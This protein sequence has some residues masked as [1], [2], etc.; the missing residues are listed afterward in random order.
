MRQSLLKF[1][2]RLA[3][4]RFNGLD[5]GN[6]SPIPYVDKK[7]STMS[8]VFASIYDSGIWGRTE[9]RSG[10][11]SNLI[12]TKVLREELP[13]LVKELR[14]SS[15]LDIPCG[16]W[17]W[18]RHVELAVEQYVGADVMPSLVESL[19]RAF[20]LP[21]REFRVLDVSIDE[22]PRVDMIF[23]RDCLVHF[24]FEHVLRTLS[25]FKRSGS[26]YLVSTTFPDRK[27]NFDIKTG[28]WRPINLCA[29]PFDLPPPIKLINE[30]CTEDFPNFIDKSLG[31]WRLS[32]M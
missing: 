11:G 13:K 2:R 31:V 4:R 26:Q 23:S 6:A 24:S 28:E 5:S 3:L 19:T 29:T 32:D 20:A 7:V 17:Y 14:V 1:A 8:A 18:M 9:S 25:N 30:G 12:Q 27:S 16:D 10:F 15:F 22:L 21:G